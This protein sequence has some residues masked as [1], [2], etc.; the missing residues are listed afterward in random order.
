MI[1]LSIWPVI[2]SLMIPS[3][4]GWAKTGV[5]SDEEVAMS[6]LGEVF[7]IVPA[8][9]VAWVVAC[10]AFGVF[11]HRV[12]VLIRLLAL[13]QPEDRFTELPRRCLVLAVRVLGQTAVVRD[14]FI[15]LVH[16]FI[17]AGFIV[18]A[19]G[20][21]F[22]LLHGLFPFLPVIDT[23]EEGNAFALL[24]DVFAVI[25]FA[26]ILVAAFR[27]YVV[28]PARLDSS[29]DALVILLLI[30]GVLSTYVLMSAGRLLANSAGAEWS[31]VSS[32]VANALSAFGVDAA[33][34]AAMF[35]GFWWLHLIIVLGFMNFIVYSKH[36]HLLGC[37]ANEFFESFRPRG[38]LSTL[39]LENSETFGVVTITDYSWKQLLD[40]YACTEC[41]RCQENC[42][43]A[44]SHKPLVPKQL[45]ADLK[46]HLLTVGPGMLGA[47]AQAKN[48]TAVAYA[49]GGE[50]LA[51]FPPLVDN[52]ITKD[53]VW[54]C[55]TC[56]YCQEH[57]PVSIEH[58]QK[59]ID[60][61][62]SLVLMETDFPSELRP[63]FKNME[64]QGNPYQISL[65]TRADWARDM[66]VPT[67]AENPGAEILYWVGCAGSFDDR[68]KKVSRSLV[69]ILKAAGVNFAIPGTEE[70]CCGDPVRRI[71]NEYMFQMLAME[72]IET[73]NGYNVKKIVAQC[74]HC[75]N[76]LLNEYPQFGGHFEVVHAT[77]YV[78]E[79]ISQGRV[80][81]SKPVS[82]AVCFHDPCYL[83]RYNKVYDA[84]RDILK[85]IP[86]VQLR[87]FG[88]NRD[89]SFCC[90][91]GGGRAFMEEHIGE[92]IN[93][94]RMDEALKAKPS[95]IGTACPY[96]LSMFEDAISARGGEGSI[97]AMDILELVGQSIQ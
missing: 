34:G 64:T 19:F 84:P 50:A 54:A 52:V 43:T 87:E 38:E 2:Q 90:G 92:R 82:E 24:L 68:N 35:V 11:W 97:K 23:I 17:F 77:E 70:K 1:R 57:C 31:P 6:P 15:G 12:Y 53:T 62:R 61:R 67:L 76:T 42:P 73:L 20:F 40:L 49:E 14:R 33:A 10:V 18:Y 63:F 65:L 27:R 85:A 59:I 69:K 47:K 48:G 66:A 3:L 95:I 5:L 37:P 78:H 30:F 41:G 9:V 28:R 16:V 81:V 83:G 74:P 86:S 51:D 4:G 21:L 7:G 88:R 71:G 29:R 25:T 94:M 46:H 75:V 60:L 8:W 13:G 26:A 58:P 44:Q 39:D 80:W 56:G 45:I 36:M 55:T 72:N 22:M 32:V 89:K 79:L 91:G 93:V 96:C